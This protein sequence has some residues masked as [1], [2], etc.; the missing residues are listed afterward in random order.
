M[1]ILDTKKYYFIL[2]NLRGYGQPEGGGGCMGGRA[3]LHG[4]IDG[5]NGGGLIGIIIGPGG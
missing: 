1:T 5:G 4:P 2:R 3:G